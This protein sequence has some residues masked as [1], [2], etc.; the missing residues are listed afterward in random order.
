[1]RAIDRVEI[2]HAG[3]ALRQPRL[4]PDDHVAVRIDRTPRRGDVRIGEV[5][6]LGRAAQPRASE[7]QQ[8]PLRFGA[9]FAIA[10]SSPILS[11]PRDP[12]STIAV[13]PVDRQCDGGISASRCA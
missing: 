10:T 5:E 12:A 7:I 9:P 2:V 1:M 8:D 4:D 3:H 6:Q 13:T 11:A